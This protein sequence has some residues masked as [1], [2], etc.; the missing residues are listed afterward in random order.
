MPKRTHEILF[1]NFCDSRGFSTYTVTEVCKALGLHPLQD[2][3]LRGPFF[4][5]FRF[6]LV[7]QAFEKCNSR[8]KMLDLV[9]THEELV[10]LTASM[11]SFISPLILFA[12]M[13]TGFFLTHQVKTFRKRQQKHGVWKSYKKSH[14]T[15]RAKLATFTFW[16]DKSSLQMTNY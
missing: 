10:K 2:S 3:C 6:D 16:E 15:M 1:A 7:R 12:L 5:T 14:S 4:S 11:D 13:S 8:E 9:V